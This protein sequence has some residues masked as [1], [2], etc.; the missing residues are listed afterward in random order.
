[1]ARQQD[2]QFYSKT[3]VQTSILFALFVIGIGFTVFTAQQKQD[4]RGK[5]ASADC[6]SSAYD[7]AVLGDNPIAY[8]PL[9]DPDGVMRDCSAG[10]KHSGTYPKPPQ[11]TTLSNGDSVKKFDGASQYGES[12]DSDDL[13]VPKTGVLTIEAWM[14]PDVLQF[15]HQE[16]TGYV[17]WL[18]KGQF[19][20]NEYVGRM[21]S[22]SNQEDRPNRISGYSFN[23]VGGWGTGS[24][25]QD[26]VTPGEWIHF[27]LVINT[28]GYTKVFK[29]GVMR[30]QDQL[31][32]YKIVPGNGKD[33]FRIGTVDFESYFPGA[34]GKVAVY[35]H[36]LTETQ[37]KA[38]Y[39]AIS[40]KSSASPT[41]PA[42]GV[43]S[44]YCLGSCPTETVSPSATIVPLRQG[45][46][47]A[48]TQSVPTSAPTSEVTPTT[49][50]CGGTTSVQKH[51]SKHRNNGG[52]FLKRV[53]GFL[54]WLFNL[55]QQLLHGGTVPTPAT[56]D[57]P[58]CTTPTP[59]ESVSPEPTSAESPSVAPTAA[60]AEPTSSSTS[61]CALPNYP[62]P[63]CTGVPTGTSLATV[64]GDVT[65]STPGQ[66]YEGKHVTGSIFVAAANVTI[67]KSQID[68]N[69]V[70]HQ[71]GDPKFTIEDST[72]GKEGSCTKDTA[73]DE[74]NYTATRVKVVGHGDGFGDS[75]VGN[76]VIQDS[77]VKLCA[78]DVSYH[79]DGVQ[80]YLGGTNVVIR[81]NTIDQRPAAIG[82]TAPVFISD[83]SKDADVQDNL[84]AGGSETIRVYY[85][86]GKDIVKNNRVV[87]KSWVYGPVSSSCSNITWA[88]NTL[89][90]I[91]ENYRVTSTVG[92]LACAN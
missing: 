59:T 86:G 81:H 17:H 56:G 13:S 77:F 2:R 36:E 27:A 44:P 72:V 16:D 71:N 84:L 8:W 33:P 35:D 11:T 4:L 48:P 23:L 34:I 80:G 45:G 51:T 30:D 63:S 43:P 57:T 1:M 42:G 47:R 79:S 41:L 37:L 21:Y 39:N 12:P 65:L 50:P 74:S 82:A 62:N 78:S 52:G 14:R 25:F 54:T 24:Y 76:I 85:Y 20:Q 67:R 40:Q 70:N 19:G 32:D 87:D 88:G 5:A 10:K 53:L 49:A 3:L 90:T 92:P 61:S 22:K 9:H 58:P 29:N 55:L 68:G 7:A 60:V 31:A 83:Q 26:P 28:K 46:T 73:I 64:T 18:G 66:V 69:V 89:V 38:H 15:P 75:G 91:D 6:P